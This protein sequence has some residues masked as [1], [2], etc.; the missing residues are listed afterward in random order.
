MTSVTC[1]TD[2][3][4]LWKHWV[5]GARLRFQQLESAFNPWGANSVTSPVQNLMFCKVEG[6]VQTKYSLR[7]GEDS[8]GDTDLNFQ[9]DGKMISMK[10]LRGRVRL[11]EGQEIVVSLNKSK[12]PNSGVAF[13]D[14]NT[15]KIYG[16][17][18][19]GYLLFSTVLAGLIG[20]GLIAHVF[21]DRA[22][23]AGPIFGSTEFNDYL[24]VFGLIG[25]SSIAAAIGCVCRI[26][27]DTNIEINLRESVKKLNAKK[28]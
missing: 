16:L 17:I 25:V 19:I 15:G 22:K 23:Q 11:F 2:S 28:N 27:R 3:S 7:G 14:V 10:S 9:C 5:D 6:P 26:A 1:L 24:Y 8:H 18:P 13:A 20:I 12:D 21:S 4:S